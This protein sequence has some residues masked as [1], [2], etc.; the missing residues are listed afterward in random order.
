M[1]VFAMTG[2]MGTMGGIASSNLN[3]LHALN[4]LSIQSN[5]QLIVLSLHES[6][7]DR[8][9]FL[10]DSVIFIGFE[11][12]RWTY[13]TRFLMLFRRNRFY[14]FDHVR[15]GLPLAPMAFLGF[16]GFVI[17][18]H[19]SESWRR[20]RGS[21]KWL[22]RRAAMCLT[23]SEYTLTKMQETFP[24]FEGRSCVLGL[25]PSHDTGATE[26]NDSV[27]KVML[28]TVDGQ[29]R[30]LGDRVILLVARMDCDEREKGHYELLTVWPSVLRD[31]P[32]A[33]LVFAGPGNDRGSLTAMAERLRVAPTVFI[34]GFLSTDLLRRLYSQCHAFVMPSRQEGFGLVYLEAM[35]RG[36]P[37]VGCRNGGSEE[38]IDD[39]GS[40]LLIDNPFEN[41]ELLRVVQRLLGDKELATRMGQ[42]GLRRFKERFTATHAQ[43]RL[44]RLLAPMLE[45]G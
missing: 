39:G 30:A 15:L 18:A 42:A 31:F 7:Q 36:K 11:G 41:E 17:L 13:A 29:T 35:N 44:R 26:S 20:V 12:N 14:V 8:P 38:I 34:P 19:G 24:G 27:T 16:H 28:P 4:D 37:C 22:F 5:R 3:V 6:E 1:V 25:P 32:D 9:S 21:S 33:Q 23:N 10:D 45:C 2:A 43:Q 40:G